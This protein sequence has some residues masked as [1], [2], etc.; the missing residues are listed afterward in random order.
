MSFLGM[1]I[2]TF[3]SMS[4][5]LGEVKKNRLTLYDE[6]TLE[7]ISFLYTGLDAKVWYWEGVK[8]GQAFCYGLVSTLPLGTPELKL[9]MLNLLSGIACSL[10]LIYKPYE[11]RKNGLLDEVEFVATFTVFI[12][13]VL[14]QF[15][16]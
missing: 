16:L 12:T 2:W 3:G 1:S 8:R 6:K 13:A 9:T 15:Y 11:F 10:H 7:R 14:F 5:M 4:L